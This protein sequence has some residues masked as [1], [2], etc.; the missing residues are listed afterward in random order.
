MFYLLRDGCRLTPQTLL[1]STQLDGYR[2][3]LPN[4]GKQE[5]CHGMSLQA[6]KDYAGQ[7]SFGDPGMWSV[8]HSRKHDLLNVAG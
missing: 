5:Q 4:Q 1:S 7:L 2:A 3:R 6:W 8:D